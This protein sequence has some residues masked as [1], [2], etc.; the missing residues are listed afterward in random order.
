MVAECYFSFCRPM[1]RPLRNII[2]AGLTALL[3]LAG[4]GAEARAVIYSQPG[5]FSES[6]GLVLWVR[7]PEMSRGSGCVAMHPRLVF[8]CAHVLYQNGWAAD[9]VSFYP[10]Y[11]SQ[12]SILNAPGVVNVRGYRR[13]EDYSTAVQWHGKKSFEAYAWD[14]VI[15]YSYFEI[16]NA[17][18]TWTT[19]SSAV[20]TSARWKRIAGYPATITATGAE[21]YYYQHRTEFFTNPAVQNN[22]YRPHHEIEGVST[23]SGNSGGPVFVYDNNRPGLAGVVVSGNAQST[24]VRALDKDTVSMA[25]RA[26]GTLTNRRTFRNV[27]SLRIPD[28]SSRFSTRAVKV[29]GFASNL[30]RVI[31]NLNVSTPVRGDLEVYLKSPSGRIRWI[32]K[33]QGSGAANLVVDGANYSDSFSGSPN[34]TWTLYMRDAVKKNMATFKSFSLAIESI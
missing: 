28:G 2:R 23:G 29:T 6:V 3:F 1:I 13:F 22:R 32:S 11:N 34:G 18:G 20:L 10:G 19:N 31:F 21:G 14:F 8:T 26:I 33:R 12:T 30:L 5:V 24:G 16:A 15:M 9:S 17:V 7:G 27:S 4:L 25:N